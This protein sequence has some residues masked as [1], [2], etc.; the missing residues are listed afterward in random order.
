LSAL[1]HGDRFKN[2]AHQAGL[3]K[4]ESGKMSHDR[5]WRTVAG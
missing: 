2:G 1:D 4:N 3:Q 5:D